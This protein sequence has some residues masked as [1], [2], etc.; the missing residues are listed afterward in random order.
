M[1]RVHTCLGR[2]KIDQKYASC[3]SIATRAEEAQPAMMAPRLRR[4]KKALAM[5]SDKHFTKHDPAI[6]T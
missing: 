6:R 1:A 2:R 5:F 3:P 4:R